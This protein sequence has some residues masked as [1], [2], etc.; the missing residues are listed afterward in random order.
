MEKTIAE[1]ETALESIGA[2]GYG[3]EHGFMTDD[4]NW[5]EARRLMKNL[6]DKAVLLNA[7]PAMSHGLRAPPVASG[8][9]Q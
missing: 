8:N 2:E 3:N 6:R 7:N 4:R 5:H 9:V 1:L